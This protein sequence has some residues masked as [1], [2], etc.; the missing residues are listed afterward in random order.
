LKGNSCPKLRSWFA[1]ETTLPL[2]TKFNEPS[3]SVTNSRQF[4]HGDVPCTQ[5]IRC[6]CHYV[7]VLKK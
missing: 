3:Y 1:W 4:D 7:W 5:P 6:S 2:L